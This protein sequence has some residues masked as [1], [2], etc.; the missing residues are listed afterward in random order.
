[1]PCIYRRAALHRI[2]LDVEIYGLDVCAGDIDPLDR[3]EISAD[4][5]ACL[6]FLRHGYSVDQIASMLMANGKLDPSYL[7]TYAR[8]VYRGMDEVRAL[9]HDKANDE[10]RSQAGL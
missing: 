6:S 1:M 7:Q 10:I 4:L 9:I 5:R 3:R 8:I 2:G